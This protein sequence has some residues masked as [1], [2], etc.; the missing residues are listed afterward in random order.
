MEK[1]RAGEWVIITQEHGQV[2]GVEGGDGTFS[3]S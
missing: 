3:L 2:S 1:C